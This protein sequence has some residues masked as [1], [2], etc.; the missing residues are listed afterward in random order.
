MNENKIF[1]DF[2]RT[3]SRQKVISWN[4]DG[5]FS[6]NCWWKCDKK[7]GKCPFCGKNGYC[8]SGY[9][10]EGFHLLASNYNYTRGLWSFQ[11]GDCPKEVHQFVGEDRH[12]CATPKEE[13]ISYIT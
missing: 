12:Y 4:G 1:V 3:T 5:Y 7:G 2:H 6:K 8:C 13:G 10:T 9:K 11:N